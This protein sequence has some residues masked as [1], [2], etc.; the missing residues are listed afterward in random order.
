MTAQGRRLLQRPGEHALVWQRATEKD[1]WCNKLH[2]NGR[3]DNDD[4][5]RGDTTIA[6]GASWTNIGW[7]KHN[8][9]ASD[10][11]VVT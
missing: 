10:P 9:L 5:V 4:W 3:R 8:L 6:V 11:D 1:E 7:S 2:A